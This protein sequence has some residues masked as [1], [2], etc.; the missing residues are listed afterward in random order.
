MIRLVRALS[1]VAVL[2][3]VLAPPAQ[4]AGDSHLLGGGTATISQ[5]AFNV[6]VSDSGTAS[7]TFTCL[8][9][10]RSAFVLPAFGLAHIMKIQ[11]TPTAGS[12]VGSKVTFSGPAGLIMDNGSHLDVH[13]QVW[14]DAATQQFQLTV[15]EVGTMDREN[16]LTGKFSLN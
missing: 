4:A 11:A 16:M 10:G 9:A 1:V 14:A 6:A 15:V 8:M 3:L 2:V 13:V 7:G 5:V 12:V